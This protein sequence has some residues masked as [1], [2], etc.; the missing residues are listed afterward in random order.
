MARARSRESVSPAQV[1][2]TA[3]SNGQPRSCQACAAARWSPAEVQGVRRGHLV[4]QLDRLAEQGKPDTELAVHPRVVLQ[5]ATVDIAHL[6]GDQGRVIAEP[7]ALGGRR[8][9]LDEPVRLAV[10][11]SRASRARPASR[12]HRAAHPEARRRETDEQVHPV[13]R[14]D[15]LLHGGEGQL[16][17]IVVQ[18]P[19]YELSDPRAAHTHAEGVLLVVEAVRQPALE[20]AGVGVEPELVDRRRVEVRVD[21]GDE[22]RVLRALPVPRVPARAAGSRRC[23]RR[24]RRRPARG[25]PDRRSRRRPGPCPMRRHSSRRLRASCQRDRFAV[26]VR[27]QHQRLLRAVGC[28]AHELE[29]L[30]ARGHGLLGTAQRH[31]QTE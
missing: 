19:A 27:G 4:V 10:A 21:A 3:L 29:S 15:G 5:P 17:R 12:G 30:R 23:R 28:V 11:C 14:R 22:I 18:A 25:G 16:D 20:E 26:R 6:V 8:R 24:R 9:H 13:H 2:E 1:S 7:G 31:R